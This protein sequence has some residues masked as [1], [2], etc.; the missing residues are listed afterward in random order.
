MQGIRRSKVVEVVVQVLTGLDAG[1]ASRERHQLRTGLGGDDPPVVRNGG[2]TCWRV[3]LQVKT[4]SA[5][6]LHY[7]VCADGSIELSS[8]RLHDDYRP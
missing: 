7:W 3:S 8:V 4:P 1:L 6:R 5:R 2:E